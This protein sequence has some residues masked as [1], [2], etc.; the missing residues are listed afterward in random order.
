MLRLPTAYCNVCHVALCKKDKERGAKA[1]SHKATSCLAKLRKHLR[2]PGLRNVSAGR[3]AKGI[4]EA[5]RWLHLR[6][7]VRTCG[8]LFQAEV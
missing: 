7:R 4:P 5:H 6:G 2:M 8:C 3:Q 1:V